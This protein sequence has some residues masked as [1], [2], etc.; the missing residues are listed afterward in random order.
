MYESFY[1][2]REKPFHVTADPAFLYPS[3]QHREA[4]DHLEYGVRERLGFIII[5][6]EVGTGKTTLAK[7]LV[8]RLQA[9]AR[10]A[11]ILN[12]ALNGAQL[13]QAILR[14][15]GEQP[16]SLNRGRLLAAI[17]RFLLGQAEKKT[18]AVLIIDEAQALGTATLEQVRLL[19]TVETSKSKLLQI[20]LVGQPELDQRL[21]RDTR[22][23]A[24]RQRITVHFRI[25]ALQPE[26]VASYVQ[27][28]LQIAGLQGDSPFSPEAMGHII[29]QSKG[30]PRRINQ[31]CDRLLLAGFVRETRRI[32]EELVME[33]LSAV[34]DPIIPTEV[35]H[36]SHC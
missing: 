20:V 22:L 34:P 21:Q 4:L 35:L 2:F 19:S 29:Q 17:E 1:G 32:K 7:T 33:T 27:H 31:L 3:R 6:G 11:L 30:I 26:E 36:E 23:R 13:L 15:F 24:L 8:Q 18:A 25:Q 28:R 12:P 10:T 16:A 5:T 9:S 14:D